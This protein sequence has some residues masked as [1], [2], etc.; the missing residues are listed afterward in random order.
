MKFLR[1]TVRFV[2]V[3]AICFV[4]QW[5]MVSTLRGV[6]HTQI[7]VAFAFIMSA[8]LNFVLSWKFTW[9]D[10]TTH[11]TSGAKAI[12]W[13]FVLWGKYNTNILL[14]AGVN[15][16]VFWVLHSTEPWLWVAILGS[17]LVSA[18]ITFTINHLIVFRKERHESATESGVLRAST[19]RG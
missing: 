5:C 1:R 15:N 19:Q 12:R 7:A 4:V 16:V 13:F 8:Q 17:N 18:V 9:R 11:K 6:M 14:A 2:L 3:G 10:H